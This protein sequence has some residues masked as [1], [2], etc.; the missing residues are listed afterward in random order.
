M[1]I[2]RGTIEFVDQA[3]EVFK[4]D[5]NLSTYRD[6][7]EGYIALRVGMFDDCIKVFE[8]GDEVGLF[9]QWC[10]RPT[11]PEIIENLSRKISNEAID[12]TQGQFDDL[13]NNIMTKNPNLKIKI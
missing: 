3:K 7:D 5:Y 4:R 2:K 10:E 6:E 9:E 13:I 11:K 8:L 12:M 1:G